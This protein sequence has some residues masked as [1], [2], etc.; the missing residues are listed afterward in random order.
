L[1]EIYDFALAAVMKCQ[2]TDRA[3]ILL[4]DSE[5]V[6]RF[7]IWHGLSDDYR[8]AV[9]GHSPWKEGARFEPVFIND[10]ACAGLDDS[11]R[12]TIQKERICSLAFIPITHEGRLIGKFMIYYNVPHEFTLDEIRPTQAVA[13]QIAFAIER[14]RTEI[15]LKHSG[16]QLLAASRAKD[17]FMAMLSHELRTPLNPVLLLASDGENNQDLPPRTRTDFNVIRKNVELEARLIDDLLDLTRITRGKIIL[18]KKFQDVHKILSDAIATVQREMEQKRIALDLQLNAARHD[19]FADAVRLQQI[20]WNLLKNA[21]KFTPE[22]GSITAETEICGDKLQIKITDTGIGMTAEEVGQVFN[23]FSQGRRMDENRQNLGGLGLGLTISQKLAEFQAGQ[24]YAAS[25]GLGKGSTF[26]VELP[27]AE[28]P[29]DDKMP[30]DELMPKVTPD[31]RQHK[32]IRVLLV[33]D[34]EPT[35]TTLAHLLA[36]RFYQ[37]A[38]A[39]S[40]AEARRLADAQRFNLLISDIGLPDGNGYDL[41]IELRKD[42]SI[43][44]IAL[45]GYGMEHDM[46]RS[47][48]AGFDVHLTKPIRIQSLEAALDAA[49]K[50]MAL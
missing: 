24:I 41:M 39:A 30:K 14:K 29:A 36:R 32:T 35:R 8:R 18:E 46:A 19:A 16:E 5:G 6:M 31:L 34:H 22:G 45:T 20:F 42:N 26:I 49:T 1:E 47:Q 25:T 38:T 48:D 21:V 13:S 23:A 4:K 3:A 10:V 9:E 7:K 11:L 17:E 28:E 43:R 15:E 12:A 50:L 40:V 2:Q 44:G 33:E 27:L 37:V